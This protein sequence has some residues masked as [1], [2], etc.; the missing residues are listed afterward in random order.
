MVMVRTEFGLAMEDNT[1][2]YS[3]LQRLRSL[4]YQRHAGHQYTRLQHAIR[5]AYTGDGSNFCL[6]YVACFFCLHETCREFRKIRKQSISKLN[7]PRNFEN[8]FVP[9]GR[10]SQH[11]MSVGR[12][13]DYSKWDHIDVSIGRGNGPHCRLFLPFSQPETGFFG[14]GGGW[15]CWCSADVRRRGHAMVEVELWLIM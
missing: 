6:F 15:G 3:N 5:V 13:F 1:E 12:A 8:F 11:T 14:V 4:V 7:F 2:W 9:T 10:A